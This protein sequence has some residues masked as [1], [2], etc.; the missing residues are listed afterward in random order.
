MGVLNLLFP[1]S[2]VSQIYSVV[3]KRHR[4]RRTSLMLTPP[5]NRDIIPTHTKHKKPQQKLDTP[6]I[7]FL[8]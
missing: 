3:I 8:L 2:W 1:N 4:L 6:P 7:Y 5:K